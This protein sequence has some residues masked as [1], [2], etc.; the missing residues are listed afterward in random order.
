MVSGCSKARDYARRNPHIIDKLV[1]EKKFP[2]LKAM[3]QQYLNHAFDK[4]RLG[5]H[6]DCDIF[7]ACSGEI[8]QLMFIGLFRNAVDSFFIQ[9]AKDSVLAKKYDT[10]LLDI[11]QCLGQQSDCNVPSTSTK[12]GFS[13]TANI[14]GHEYAGCLFVILTSFYTSRFREFFKSLVPQEKC[15]TSSKHYPTQVL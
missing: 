13:S 11:N 8:L 7:G 12:K 4:V 10:L 14:P 15:P 1:R 6:N 3:S 9:I 5:M 2:E